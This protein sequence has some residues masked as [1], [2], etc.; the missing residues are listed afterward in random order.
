MTTSDEDRQHP[1]TDEDLGPLEDEFV[2]GFP[3]R[4]FRLT[5]FFMTLDDPKVEVV[6]LDP[7]T[8]GGARDPR[9]NVRYTFILTGEGGTDI[10]HRLRDLALRFANRK[11][12]VEPTSFCDAM[13]RLRSLILD[14]DRIRRERERQRV[15]NVRGARRDEQRRG[16][17]KATTEHV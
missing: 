17:G 3:T 10:V 7:H 15:Q 13:D 11:T 6:R 5:A 2:Q 4:D 14:T 12:L 8:Y 9:K 1:K 16:L